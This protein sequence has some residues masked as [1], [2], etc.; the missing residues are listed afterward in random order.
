VPDTAVLSVWDAL[1]LAID[2]GQNPPTGP[3]NQAILGSPRFYR[4]TA[5]TTA[6]LGYFILGQSSEVDTGFYNGQAGQ[7]GRYRIHCWST[8]P[9]HANRLYQWLK[10]LIHDQRLILQGH[11]MLRGSLSKLTDQPDAD[12]KAWQVVAD[13]AVESLEA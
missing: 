5:P 7:D 9:T 10:R 6:G 11:G 12:G 1:G 3:S 4:G 2:Q 13:Y 8:T